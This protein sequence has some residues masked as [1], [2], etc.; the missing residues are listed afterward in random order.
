MAQREQCSRDVDQFFD[1]PYTRTSDGKKC[2]DCKIC[3]KSTLP[4]TLVAELLTLWWHLESAHRAEYLK[5]V[6]ENSFISMLPKDRKAQKSNEKTSQQSQLNSHLQPMVS[7]EKVPDYSD[8]WFHNAAIQWLVNTNQPIAA[9]KHPS[10]QHI[11]NVAVRTTN[12]V[13]ILSQKT[14]QEAIIN[15][16]EE[17][18]VKL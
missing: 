1:A 2:R 18:M 12:G 17:Q 5:W 3:S 15:S 16:L 14:T 11:I 8:M 7:N 13:K 6:K 9:L 4:T 10:F